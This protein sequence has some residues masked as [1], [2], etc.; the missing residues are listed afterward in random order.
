VRS[1]PGVDR[2][3]AAR[4]GLIYCRPGVN[5]PEKDKKYIIP[6]EEVKVISMDW[7]KEVTV[8][9]VKAFGEWAKK[10]GVGF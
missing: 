3:A 10:I 7:N 8:E 6:L 4:T 1:T 9:A 5:F 2:M